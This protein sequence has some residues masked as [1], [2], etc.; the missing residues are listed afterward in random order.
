MC[1][2]VNRIYFFGKIADCHKKYQNFSYDFYKRLWY[3]DNKKVSELQTVLN[4]FYIKIRLKQP[5]RESKFL[6]QL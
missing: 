6:I 3:F 2:R 4:F 1:K 5:D